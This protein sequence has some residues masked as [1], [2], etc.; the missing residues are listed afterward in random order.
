M[1]A[2]GFD[3]FQTFGPLFAKDGQFDIAFFYGN[4][5]FSPSD[6]ASAPIKKLTLNFAPTHKRKAGG[7][8]F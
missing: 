5:G 3:P 2:P 1:A 4:T 7:L 6:T 8:P